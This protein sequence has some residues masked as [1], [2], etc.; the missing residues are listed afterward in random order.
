MEETMV[1]Q[2]RDGDKW[3]ETA[4]TNDYTS[5]YYHLARDIAAK[6]LNG[7]T[8]IKSIKRVQLYNGFIKIIVTQFNNYRTI[9]VVKEF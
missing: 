3:I 9:Y 1:L 2:K 5:I 4:R 6:K 8:W 7:C